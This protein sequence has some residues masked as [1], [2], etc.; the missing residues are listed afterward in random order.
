LLKYPAKAYFNTGLSQTMGTNNYKGTYGYAD[1]GG[2]FHVKPSLS[3]YRSDTSNGTYKTFAARLAKDT[4]L[5]GWGITLGASPKVNDYRNSFFG[6][7][8]TFSFTPTGSGPARRLGGPQSGGAPR[9]EGLARVDMGGGVLHTIH[10]DDIQSGSNSGKGSFSRRSAA[11]RIGQTDLQIFA[12]ISFMDT[13]LSGQITKSNYNKDLAALSARVAQRIE[14]AGV[15][16]IIQGFPDTSYNLRIEWP[17]LP[18][19]S[20]FLSH[21]FTKFELGAPSSKDYSAGAAIGLD[22][23]ELTVSYERYVPGGGESNLNYY[24]VG[25]ALRF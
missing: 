17:M 22:M 4:S 5:W 11:A 8:V 24:S 7:D 1:V 15:A 12:G 19:V 16:A 3:V 2:E 25:A 10:T 6:A 13:L 18:L 23:L 14:L 20:P 21:T 9:G